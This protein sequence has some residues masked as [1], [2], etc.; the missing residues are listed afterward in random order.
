L[1]LLLDKMKT[2][3][4]NRAIE[5]RKQQ[6]TYSEIAASLNV[7]KGALSRWLRGTSYTPRPEVLARGRLARCRNSQ[8]LHQRKTNRIALI[9]ETARDDIPKLGAKELLILGSMAYWAE[10]SK[11]KDSIVKF[12]NTEPELILLVLRWLKEICGVPE[13]KLRFH[14]RIHPGEDSSTVERFW[15]D[16]TRI[17]KSQ[18]YRTTLKL[19]GSGGRTSKKLR[20]GIASIIVCDTGLFYRIQGWIEGIKA[21]LVP[22][23]IGVPSEMRP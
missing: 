6:R 20:Y 1:Q 12:T 5:L 22:L 9:R 7:S 19:S 18:F 17:P 23:L 15:S 13:Y 4:R 16:L 14:I 3:E 21:R 10:G 8:I 2:V 11:T